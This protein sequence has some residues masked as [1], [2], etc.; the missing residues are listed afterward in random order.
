MASTLVSVVA[1]ASSVRADEPSGVLV[2]D[3]SVE[4]LSDRPVWLEQEDRDR[5]TW[6]PVCDSPCNR[7]FRSDRRY[8]VRGEGVRQTR[9]IDVRPGEAI[10]LDVRTVSSATFAWGWVAVASG[11]IAGVAGSAMLLAPRH[12]DPAQEANQDRARL[13]T[14]LLLGGLFVAGTGIVLAIIGGRS[15]LREER[16]A[17][18]PPP[19]V[20]P[21]GGRRLERA[22]SEVVSPPGA[23][24]LPIVS[25]TF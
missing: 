3:F 1:I 17:P 8:R 7:S 24:G 19:Q 20:Q 2:P 6:V 5:G 4:I 12:G 11:V 16:G 9:P 23:W 18:P 25:G 13:G 15:S 10:K 14:G 21:F 22:A